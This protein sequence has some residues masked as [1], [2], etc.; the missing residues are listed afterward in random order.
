MRLLFSFIGFLVLLP[1]IHAQEQT[2]RLSFHGYLKE[3][4]GAYFTD[5]VNSFYSSTLIHN[6]LNMGYRFNQN[7]SGRLELRNRIFFGELVSRN[8]NFGKVINQSDAIVS[9]SNL[10][11]DGR[12]LVIHSVIDRMQLQYNNNQWDI[13]LGRQRIN[14]GLHTV[15]N[16][17]DIFNAFNFLDF[18]YEERA[19]TDALRVQRFLSN[20][21]GFDLAYRPSNKKDQ[22]I[23]ALLY[24]FNRSGYD[25]QVLAG[26]YKSDAV[27]GVGWAGNIQQTGFKG[28]CSFFRP[29]NMNS[30]Q[31]EVLSL[32]MQLD[33]TFTGNWYASGAWLYN[34]WVNPGLL[35][36]AGM[37]GFQLSPKALFPFHH[38]F[39]GAVSKA[40]NPIHQVS[41][42]C[43]WSPTYNTTVLVP[44]FSWSIANNFDLDFTLQSF[45]MEYLGMFRLAGNSAFLRGRWSF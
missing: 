38:S 28:E 18:D 25:M 41:M 4:Q 3:M 39:Y 16:P 34:S 26:K 6:R 30:G 42:A 20:G 21:S 13:R 15:W 8:S 11:V 31:K 36:T 19:G 44:T 1:A 35:S 40:P 5:R 27:L 37:M 29:L 9:L 7:L 14:W 33:R 22:D 2:P 24:R 12:N 17:N 32:S 10:W 43:I 23:G 45:W